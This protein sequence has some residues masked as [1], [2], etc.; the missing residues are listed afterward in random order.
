MPK[1]S[2]GRESHMMNSLSA[3]PASGTYPFPSACYIPSAEPVCAAA[4]YA[5]QVKDGLFER[6]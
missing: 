3:K 2:L 5:S 6:F 4:S 1:Y